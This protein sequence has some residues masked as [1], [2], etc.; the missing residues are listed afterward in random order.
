MS[1][2]VWNRFRISLDDKRKRAFRDVMMMYVSFVVGK[3]R[4][5]RYRVNNFSLVDYLMSSVWFCSLLHILSVVLLSCMFYLG[6]FR[7]FVRAFFSSGKDCSPLSKRL[8]LLSLYMEVPV[9]RREV[10]KW[11]VNRIFPGFIGELTQGSLRNTMWSMSKG[12]IRAP[13]VHIPSLPKGPFLDDIRQK[14]DFLD[15]VPFPKIEKELHA[16]LDNKV[17]CIFP[18]LFGLLP[19]LGLVVF[20]FFFFGS[21]FVWLFWFFFCVCRVKTSLSRLNLMISLELGKPTISFSM[22][23]Y[24]RNDRK[25]VQK[26][27]NIFL[28][29]QI[30]CITVNVDF[31]DS[32]NKTVLE[33][34]Q[35]L[36]LRICE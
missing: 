27:S 6:L 28:P 35:T 31:L 34:T 7:R 2:C 29:F 3:F 12:V 14:L 4:R 15:R 32:H 26:R 17:F 20:C 9:V 30:S 25:N 10:V 33:L 1:T 8:Q 13:F 19:H 23:R 21:V 18:S 24:S 5:F 36:T 16:L 22:V 11:G